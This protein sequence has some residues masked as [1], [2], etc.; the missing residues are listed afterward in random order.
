MKALAV[1]F[2]VLAAAPQLFSATP[3]AKDQVRAAIDG[4]VDLSVKPGGKIVVTPSKFDASD[5][6]DELKLRMA[7]L[8]ESMATAKKVQVAVK[9]ILFADEYDAK[10]DAVVV[11]FSTPKG[12]DEALFL[13]FSDGKWQIFPTDLVE[14]K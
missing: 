6:R 2:S 12:P 7:V 11:V 1:V 4:G 8:A 14:S 5:R 9:E 3:N 13:L 10:H